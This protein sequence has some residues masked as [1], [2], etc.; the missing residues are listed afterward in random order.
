[1]L[2]GMEAL[3]RYTGDKK[4]YDYIMRYADEHVDGSGSISGYTGESLDDVM[5]GSILVWAYKETRD[6]KYKL[7]CE[8]IRAGF[9][10][11]P[12]N[13]DGGF[14]HNRHL[15][16]EMWVDGV[17]MGLMFL[18]YYGCYIGDAG[19]CFDEAARQLNVIYDRCNKDNT[20]LILHAFSEDRKPSWADKATGLSSDVWSEGLGWYALILARVMEVFPKAHIKYDGLVKQYRELLYSL[21][22][23]QDKQT[24]R[25]FQVVDKGDVPGNWT[26]T[27]GSAMFAYSIQK[28][29][30]LD[31][32]TE[33]EFGGAVKKAYE[34]LIEMA[35]VNA[36]G[37][38]DIYGACD[39]LCVQDS[40]EDYIN[41]EKT[42]NAKEC[43]AAF[44]WAA[45]IIEKPHAD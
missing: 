22:E 37:L 1:M 32:V 16:H 6:E 39:G 17:F 26:D 23:C 25:W 44:L 28:A 12:R 35:K 13:S 10:D 18:A 33:R 20:G 45:A 9:N 38:L 19:Y 15:P 8:K 41:Y 2:W 43:V 40:Y 24:G 42:V 31:I 4:Y 14:W 7:A 5:S 36:E 11:Y 29:V 34:G 3:Y 27:S 21:K 30:E